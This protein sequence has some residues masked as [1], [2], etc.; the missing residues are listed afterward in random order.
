[1]TESVF[2]KIGDRNPQF[3]RE[4]K[5]RLKRL[6]ILLTV[7][8]SLLMQT[9]VYINNQRFD[10]SLKEN[11][12]NWGGIVNSINLLFVFS[13]LVCGTYQ[14]INDISREESRGTLNFIRLSPQSEVSILIGKI[15][16]VPILLYL[17]IAFAIPFHLV[18]E[19]CAGIPFGNILG[20]YIIL[21]SCC[22]LVFSGATLISL[23][24]QNIPS[25]SQGFLAWLASAI[26]LNL[27][28]F[29]YSISNVSD[30]GIS[31]NH[32]F[33]WLLMFSPFAI[34]NYLMADLSNNMAA[35]ELKNLQFFQIPVGL[36]IITVMSIYLA[37]YAFWIF[38]I[39]QIIKRIFRN[40]KS[41]WFSKN[42]SYFFVVGI[43][44]LLWGFTL[45]N[46]NIESKFDVSKIS[47]QIEQNISYFLLLN[48]ILIYSL[49]RILSPQRQD[50]LDW[51]RYRRL[52][53][54]HNQDRKNHLL[55]DLF[56]GEKSP[57]QL[58]I[59]VNLL[60]IIVPFLAWIILSPSFAVETINSFLLNILL[61]KVSNVNSLH[62]LLGIG[63]FFVL[64]IIYATIYQR[65]ALL[66]VSQPFSWAMASILLLNIIP[67]WILMMMKIYP[68]QNP[69][70]WLFSTFPWLGFSASIPIILV[71]FLSEIMVLVV[72]NLQFMRWSER[73][74]NS[75]TKELFT[76][77]HQGN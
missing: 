31:L 70:P 29:S 62:L 34:E 72:C 26:V 24:A 37:N 27:L 15:L 36:N 7:F 74:G 12:S 50:I 13:L 14:I 46:Q 2:E 66:P 41:T 4:V 59:A 57:S 1:M 44:I 73:V 17:F 68:S 8:L 40:Q 55:E 48:L 76:V 23:M 45:Q 19:I 69:I 22:A 52:N 32:A 25:N 58:A 11:V 42:Y 71:A 61:W 75:T 28:I 16:G 10:D 18:S 33:A 43:Q 67:A 77:Q 30:Y 38:S 20:F 21:G 5:G 56:L 54:Q 47:Y 53:R 39:W 65:L 3:V 60:L 35:I 9:L 49:M 51:S 63:C 6:P 64:T